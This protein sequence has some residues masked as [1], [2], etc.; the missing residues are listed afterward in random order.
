MID[1][2]YNCT[3]NGHAVLASGEIRKAIGVPSRSSEFCITTGSLCGY[4]KHPPIPGF[5]NTSQCRVSW[6]STQT[7]FGGALC[8]PINA[9]NYLTAPGSGGNMVYTVGGCNSNCGDAGRGGMV[10]ITYC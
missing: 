3:F 9:N 8:S 5:A 7:T 2:Y 4:V 1:M 6:T 10:R